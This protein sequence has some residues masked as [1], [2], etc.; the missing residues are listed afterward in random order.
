[1]LDAFVFV[2]TQFHTEC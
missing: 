2:G 1:M